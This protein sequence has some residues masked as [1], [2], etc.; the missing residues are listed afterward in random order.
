MCENWDFVIPVCCVRMLRFLRLH[1]TLPCVL[2]SWYLLLREFVDWILSFR[3]IIWCI[4]LAS[5]ASISD[6]IVGLNPGSKS[7]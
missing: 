4:I 1:D 7:L 3:E 6:Q 5:L 2:L